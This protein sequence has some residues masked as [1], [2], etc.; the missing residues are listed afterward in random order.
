[1]KNYTVVWGFIRF[2]FPTDLWSGRRF[3][4]GSEEFAER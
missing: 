4:F 1:M 3:Q 2:R